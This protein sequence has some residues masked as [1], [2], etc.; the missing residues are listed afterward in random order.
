MYTFYCYGLSDAD[1]Y[2]HGHAW[3]LK[4]GEAPLCMRRERER[5]RKPGHSCFFEGEPYFY[6]ISLASVDEGEELL[7]VLCP[8]PPSPAYQ[9]W[10][11]P[12]VVAQ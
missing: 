2:G 6:L 11:P 9:S 5:E 1:V 7:L 8:L 12:S 3:R 10:D 4:K